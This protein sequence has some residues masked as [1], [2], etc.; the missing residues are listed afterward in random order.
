MVNTGS[1]NPP[2][3]QR[4]MTRS[5]STEKYAS[6]VCTHSDGFGSKVSRDRRAE[7]FNGS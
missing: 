7:T 1:I 2:D 4:G 6:D 5:Q 3:E